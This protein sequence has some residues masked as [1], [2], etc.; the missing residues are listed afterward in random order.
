MGLRDLRRRHVYPDIWRRGCLRAC[1]KL[2]IGQKLANLVKRNS[3][4]VTRITQIL[5]RH[6]VPATFFIVGKVIERAGQELVDLLDDDYLFDIGSHTYSHIGI[7]SNN[8]EVLQQLDQELIR[9]SEL[10]QKCFDRKPLGFCAP[11][12]FYRGLRGHP[13][14]LWILWERGHR[15]IRTNGVGPPEQPMPA[16]FT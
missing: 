15:F 2:R 10:I 5:K 13:K 11:G 9:T 6:E 3:G 4:S 16:L 7:L 14:E 8:S 1:P 12:G